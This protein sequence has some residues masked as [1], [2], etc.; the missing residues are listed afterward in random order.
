MNGLALQ[1]Q[2]ALRCDPFER[3]ADTNLTT[4]SSDYMMSFYMREFWRFVNVQ[5]KVAAMAK[6]AIDFPP[7]QRGASFNLDA[8]KEQIQKAIAAKSSQ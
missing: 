4:G 2:E 1:V 6:T 7:M 8:V 5:Q 3:Y